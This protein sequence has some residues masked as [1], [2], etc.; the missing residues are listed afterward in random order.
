MATTPIEKKNL[1]TYS[2]QEVIDFYDTYQKLE[3]PEETIFEIL[4]TELSGMTVLDVG[5]G[6]GRT[7]EFL[8]PKVSSY[9]AIDYSAG[10]VER[11]RTKFSNKF[12]KA[13][14]LVGDARDLSPFGKSNFNFVLFSLNG[15]DYVPGQSRIDFFRNA[16]TI[17]KPGGYLCFSTHNLGFLKRIRVLSAAHLSL[18]VFWMLKK[19]T[20]IQKLKRM[21]AEALQAAKTSDYV[22]IN[23]G[24]HNFGLAQCYVRT[25]FQ[26]GM[27][28]ECGF[29]DI[30]VFSS[31]TGKSI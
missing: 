19:I 21:N 15:I 23:D 4:K 17:T 2:A 13:K 8:A 14:F 27:L 25:A 28:R 26:V 12:P 22:F 10:M 24:A 18:N 7:T 3:L 31:Q 29:T 11:C 9:T 6:G 5:V 1:E 30:R 20:R 16:R